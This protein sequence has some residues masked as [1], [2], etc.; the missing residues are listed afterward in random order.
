MLYG[1][2]TTVLDSSIENWLH[3]YHQKKKQL[4]SRLK[5][6]KYGDPQVLGI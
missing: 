5:H 4:T 2:E 6:Q 3:S 1:Q